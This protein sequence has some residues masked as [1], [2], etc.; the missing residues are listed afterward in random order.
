MKKLSL[1]EGL[2]HKGRDLEL[3]KTRNVGIIAHIDA[4]K[5]TTTE[6]IL[7][8]TGLKS[9]L[10][11]V[12]DGEATTDW[13]VQEKERGITITSAVIQTKWKVKVQSKE[14]EYTVNIIDTPGHVDFTIEVE[15]SLR[16]LDGAVIVLESV[17][18]VQT[19]TV[20]VN[21]QARKYKVPRI[22]FINKMDRIGADFYGAVKSVKDKLSDPEAEE[23]RFIPVVLQLPVGS[24]AN[25]TGLIDLVA[26]KYLHWIG[27]KGEKYEIRDIPTDMKAKAQ[28]YHDEML[29]IIA[30][31]DDT[32][33]EKFLEEGD[34]PEE[35]INY[36]IRLGTLK[37]NLAPILCGS[38][39]K[40]IGVQAL[41][42]CMVRYLPCPKDKK[43]IAK[44][45]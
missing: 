16:V 24:E 21:R 32:L 27:E 36:L 13:M 22:I 10:G 43:V 12:H 4:G 45:T 2:T 31:E 44:N 26:M 33:M 6:R 8:F 14:E 17:S 37:N 38:S 9:S 5:T 7:F 25:F 29:D 23:G 34:L 3:F 39:Y 1:E 35:D 30:V 28:Q 40:N 15:R 11:E 42:D 41:L 18:G 20:T 19:Q